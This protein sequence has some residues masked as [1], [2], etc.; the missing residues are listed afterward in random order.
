MPRIFTRGGRGFDPLAGPDGNRP[1]KNILRSAET[2]I[3]PIKVRDAKLMHSGST[4]MAPS[5]IVLVK[6]SDLPTAETKNCFGTGMMNFP[7]VHGKDRYIKGQVKV[8]SKLPGEGIFKYVPK[9]NYD[10]RGGKWLFVL[11][12]SLKIAREMRKCTS[13]RGIVSHPKLAPC[14]SIGG[15]IWF[16]PKNK[17]VHFNLNSGR[18]PSKNP[19]DLEAVAKYLLSLDYKKVYAT[20]KDQ[21]YGEITPILY[22]LDDTSVETDGK[23]KNE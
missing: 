18:F 3:K 1:D 15:E 5:K 7:K 10:V 16:L 13:N 22:M 8:K 11:S 14:A 20:P 2:K 6:K 21:R 17:S 9:I 12:D 23:F 19:E 4:I